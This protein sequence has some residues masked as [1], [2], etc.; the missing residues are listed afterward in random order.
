ME[1]IQVGKTIKDG[2]GNEWVIA[3]RY[4][5]DKFTD[6][7]LINKITGETGSLRL[8]TTPPKGEE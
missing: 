8:D 4:I 3:R 7:E 5:N 6:L 1:E 2:S